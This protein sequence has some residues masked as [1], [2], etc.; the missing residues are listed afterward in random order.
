ML[1][2]I[3]VSS[4]MAGGHAQGTLGEHGGMG[5]QARVPTCEMIMTSIVS[6]ALGQQDFFV[7]LLLYGS[8][9]HSAQCLYFLAKSTCYI[10]GDLTIKMPVMS[11]LEWQKKIK[12]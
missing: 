2:Q 8:I 7:I 4:D 5:I 6:V 3:V 1:T 9:Q 11:L 10:P 12:V